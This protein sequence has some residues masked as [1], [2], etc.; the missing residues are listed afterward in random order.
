MQEGTATS[1]T[2]VA[3]DHHASDAVLLAVACVA[4]FMVVLDV[5]IVN[6]ALP[7][8][9]ADLHYSATGLQWVVNAYVLTFAGFLLLGGRLADLFGRRRVFVGGLVLF[10]VASL[11]G[12]LAQSSGELT[13]ARAVQ[14]LGG[15][16]LSPATLTIIMTTFTEGEGRH[17]AL[18]AWSATAGLG[19][20]FGVILGGILTSELSWRWVFYV[21][22]PI[23]IG[24]GVAA[25][26]VLREMKRPDAERA[27]D[28]T[29]SI[30]A[31]GGLALLVYAIVG[32]DTHPWGSGRTL[33]LL[34]ASAVLLVVFVWTQTKVKSPLMP[35]SLFRSRTVSAANITMLLL[36]VAFFSMWY[37]LSLY[38]QRVKGHTPL[39]AGLLFLPMS[40][41]IIIGAQT[42][43]RIIGRVGPRALLFVGLGMSASGFAWL[44]QLTAASSYVSGMLGGTLLISFGVG[45]CFTPLA[46]AATTGVHW[47]QAGLASGVLNTARQV[48]G[49]IGLAA[50]A[51]VATTRTH[52]LLA[53]NS[54]R[55]THALTVNPLAA[56]T[57]GYD[58]AF[59]GAAIACA[60]AA[61]T[62]LA[63]PGRA[64][65]PA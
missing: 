51:T 56:Q 50:L 7:K 8:I 15:A 55:Y 48:G 57:S 17:R 22:I 38:L 12:G 37:F 2:P 60:V 47:T 27:I 65:P 58:H 64:A 45:L 24:A 42:A 14:G 36:G 3:Q 35:L 23:G 11:L 13:A 63:I 28:V 21:N 32:T 4:Q 18:G 19:G 29:G 31:T 41:A 20:A 62:A 53:Q 26:A 49:S 59:A 61:L 5:S 1:S 54:F 9:G 33:G 39:H 52:D 6:V 25:L 30:L 43:G 16:V 34:A 40:A 44:T 10:S 46:T